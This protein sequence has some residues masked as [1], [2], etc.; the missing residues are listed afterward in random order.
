VRNL[1]VPC[2]F[3]RLATEWTSSRPSTRALGASVNN[4][5]RLTHNT[6]I[7][8]KVEN[9]VAFRILTDQDGLHVRAPL[10][11]QIISDMHPEVNEANE[12]SLIT[13]VVSR[14]KDRK[15][16]SRNYMMSLRSAYRTSSA[17]ERRPSLSITLALYVSTV[18]TLRLRMVAI[19]LL[20]FP[21]AKCCTT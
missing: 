11:D 7:L 19:S 4:K 9:H 20:V 17:T 18:L 21:I 15:Q 10:G 8:S 14:N 6:A 16:L 13:D 1:G 12:V 2:D 3:Q 5:F